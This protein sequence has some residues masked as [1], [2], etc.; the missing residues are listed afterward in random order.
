MYSRGLVAARYEGGTFL[1]GLARPWMGLH[2]IDT[3]RRDA[4]EKQLWFET[5]HTPGSGKAE[6]AVIAQDSRL[7]YTIDLEKDVVERIEFTSDNGS[8]GALTFSYLKGISGVESKFIGPSRK[9]YR[10]PQRKSIGI[11]WL[12]RL[13]EGELK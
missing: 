3:I 7:L 9:T 13:M 12:I 5:R 1:K 11:Q 4:A 10:R 6:V 8:K 2:A